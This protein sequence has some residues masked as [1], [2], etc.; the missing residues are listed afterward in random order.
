[1]PYRHVEQSQLPFDFLEHRQ[2]ADA[3]QYV[4]FLPSLANIHIREHAI[5]RFLYEVREPWSVLNP[6]NAADYLF[7]FVYPGHPAPMQE[8]AWTL[9]LNIKYRITHH[10]MV[11]RGQISS[12]PIRLAEILRAPVRVGA[13]N[14]I[15]V[16]NHP[17]GDPTPSPQDVTLT[18]HLKEASD[19]LGIDLMDHIIV[20]DRDW[21]SMREQKLGFR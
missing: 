1:M 14:I 21:V 2:E 11:Y 19:L 10:A 18:E 12:V 7:R 15:L 17:S 3:P 16:H 5:D 13:A 8:E 9:M 6:R 20:G 4:D